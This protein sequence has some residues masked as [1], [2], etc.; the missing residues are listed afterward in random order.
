MCWICVL[1][2]RGFLAT[3]SANK[4]QDAQ[5]GCIAKDLSR[6]MEK[7]PVPVFNVVGRAGLT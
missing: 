6:G 2:I 3:R 4:S 1:Q 7:L 5:P